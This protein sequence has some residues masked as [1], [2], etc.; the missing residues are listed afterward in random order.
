MSAS[1]DFFWVGNHLALDFVN[2]LAAG[3][4]GPLELLGSDA[5][6]WRWARASELAERVRPAQRSALRL[7]PEVPRLRAA[8]HALFT[9]RIDSESPPRGALERLNEVLALP[10]PPARLVFG[11]GRYQRAREPL[12]TNEDLL[13]QLAEASAELLEGAPAE[14][15]RRCA[16]EG[17]VLLF[18]DVSKAGRR[19]WCS[20]A[21]CGNRAKV[22]AHYHRT[23]EES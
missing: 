18:L 14:R 3:P 6:L 13:R 20:M 16:G 7:E 9:A 12:T 5:D 23:R 8:L 17:C 11:A 19:R 4:E 21:G 2:T 1:A 10:R 22:R 15:L